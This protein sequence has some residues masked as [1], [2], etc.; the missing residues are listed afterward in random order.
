M[1]KKTRSSASPKTPSQTPSQTPSKTP[2]ATSV[3]GTPVKSPAAK[4]KKT[5]K[6][7]KATNQKEYGYVSKSQA[8]KALA[9]LKNFIAR[10]KQEASKEESSKSDLFADEDESTDE[11]SDLV[12]K[13]ELKKFYTKKAEFK[14]KLITLTKPYKNINGKT[15]TCLFLRDQFINTEEEVEKIEEANIPTL[16]KI[17][18][19][20]QLKTIYKPFEKRRE[21]LKEY[22]MFVVDDAILSSIPSTLGKTFYQ[23]TSK[24]PV[25]VRVASTKTPKQLSYQ[26]LTNQINKALSSTA[27]LPPVGS[28]ISLT[29]GNLAADFSEEDF[30]SNLEQVLKQFPQESLITVGL[31][32]AGSPVLPLYYAEKIYDDSDVLENVADKDVAEVADTEDVY[33]KALLELA[34]ENTVKQVLGKALKTHKKKNSKAKTTK[35]EGK[36]SK[37]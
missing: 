32:A 17:L 34:D 31:Q 7:K 36:V 18:T 15:K 28:D 14:P 12:V 3:E 11:K 20:T 19:L 5:K 37:P 21:L 27:F 2:V 26:T 16:A 6:A 24:F 30:L 8:S 29:I 23:N 4:A 35:S 13:F 22:D 25:P 1:A 10:S 33:T 9:E